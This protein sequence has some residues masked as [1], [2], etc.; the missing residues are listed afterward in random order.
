MFNN[1]AREQFNAVTSFIDASTVYGSD[2]KAKANLRD[3]ER[4]QF[5]KVN[6]QFRDPNGLGFLPFSS[7]LCV[8]EAN[9]TEP[10]VRCFAAGDGRVTEVA[11]LSALI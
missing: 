3:P 8:Q 6:D 11:P 9:S 10:E 5:M 4:P 7:D 2:E 1:L